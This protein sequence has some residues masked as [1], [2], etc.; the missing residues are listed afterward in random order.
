MMEKKYRFINY[1]IRVYLCK[2]FYFF[3]ICF[4]EIV[5]LMIFIYIYNLKFWLI[6][7]FIKKE[8]NYDDKIV[9]FFVDKWSKGI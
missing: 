7:Y 4:L 5:W 1:K 8:R 2:N 9:N 6:C 3:L